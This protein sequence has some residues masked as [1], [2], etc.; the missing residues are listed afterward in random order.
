MRGSSVPL[1]QAVRRLGCMLRTY[2]KAGSVYQTTAR[3]ETHNSGMHSH[4]SQGFG[5]QLPVVAHGLQ[6]L[7]GFHVHQPVA[8]GPAVPAVTTQML[9]L[10]QQRK[11]EKDW[12][13]LPLVAHPICGAV[14]ITRQDA[15]VN[16]ASDS[17]AEV[18]NR[19]E[20]S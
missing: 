9:A 14:H 19:S 11:P 18:H 15:W 7:H 5:A 10:S 17:S 13:A 8:G 4:L 20:P 6:L 1:L 16:R 12:A 3:C 2:N